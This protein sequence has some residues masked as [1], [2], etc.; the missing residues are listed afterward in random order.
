MELLGAGGFEVAVV[1]GT[2]ILGDAPVPPLPALGLAGG[3]LMSL[4]TLGSESTFRL[5]RAF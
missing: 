2:Y 1:S 3:F 5:P 4:Q